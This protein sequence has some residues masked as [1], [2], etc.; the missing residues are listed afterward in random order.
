MVALQR[1][2]FGTVV[3]LEVEGKQA[4]AAVG[5]AAAAVVVAVAAAV[6]AAAA[7]TAAA[8]LAAAMW[9]GAT[10]GYCWTVEAGVGEQSPS[11][12]LRRW[13]RSSHA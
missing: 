1:G 5:T 11:Q 8:T 10:G 9:L 7:D 6:V 4:L 12:P 13:K 3:V 2:I